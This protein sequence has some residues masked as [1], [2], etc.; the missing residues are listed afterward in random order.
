MPDSW[1]TTPLITESDVL[2]KLTD[3]RG[4]QW[5]CRGQSKCYDSLVPSIDRKPR[6][7]LSRVEKLTLEGRSIDLFRSTARF[8]ADPGEQAALVND[9]VALM[10]L[11]H[12]GV[13][14]RLLDWTSSPWVAAYFAV[15]NHDDKD[16]ELWAFDLRTYE[17]RGHKQWQKW[18]E[19][20]IN[21]DGE[22]F[23]ANLT[24]FTYEEP[25]DWFVCHFYREGFHRQRAQQSAYS[26]T[27]RFN[28]PHDAAIADLLL[29][30]STYHRYVIAGKLKPRLRELL[31]EHHGIWRG[32]LFPDSAGAAETARR[33]V[34]QN[35]AGDRLSG[36]G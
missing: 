24:A 8:F 2:Q 22:H 18:P 23:D 12:Y 15:S 27:A 1:N 30:S 32:S 9:I 21:R 14:S 29:N 7:Q 35:V 28:R 34:F 31:R 19:T 11:R 36:E 33:M 4:R 5:L 16:G 10:V 3:L 20:T 17:V 13:P 6:Q 25:P 26:M